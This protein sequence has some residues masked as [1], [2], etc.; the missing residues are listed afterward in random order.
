MSLIAEPID[1]TSSPRS[2]DLEPRFDNCECPAV[3][4]DGYM[5]N[6]PSLNA[7]PRRLADAGTPRGFALTEP[8]PKAKRT[9]SATQT[10][11]IHGRI[12]RAVALLPRIR[13]ITECYPPLLRR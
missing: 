4:L 9:K 3:R 6:V 1:R 7:G 8:C 5:A 12:I 2:G 11:V 13:P 10:D